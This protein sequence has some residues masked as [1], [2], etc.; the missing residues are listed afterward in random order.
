MYDVALTDNFEYYG[1][2]VCTDNTPRWDHRK[3]GK[4]SNK[5]VKKKKKKKTVKTNT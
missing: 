4:I 5:V 3:N 1:Q 2:S